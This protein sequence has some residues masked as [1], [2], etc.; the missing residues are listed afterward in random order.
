MSIE[1]TIDI[2]E[3]NKFTIEWISQIY[4]FQLKLRNNIKL[5]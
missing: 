1:H 2:I 3:I 4:I 5:I